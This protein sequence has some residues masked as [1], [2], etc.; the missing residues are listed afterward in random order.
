MY[1]A[2]F[3]CIMHPDPCETRKLLVELNAFHYNSAIKTYQKSGR[4]EL[5]LAS[6]DRMVPASVPRLGENPRDHFR[7]FCS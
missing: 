4:W 2:I 3:R 1:K 7:L 5:A 6:L